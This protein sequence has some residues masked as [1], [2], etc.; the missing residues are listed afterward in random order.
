MMLGTIAINIIIVWYEGGAGKRLDSELL[1]ADSSGTKS[2]I[3]VSF[4][5][6]VGAYFV[7]H[8]FPWLDGVITLVIA[9]FI[10]HIIVK[11]V[12]S[13]VKV[14]CDAQ[15]IDPQKIIDVV[16]SV[17][18]VR[19]CRAVRTRGRETGFYA[20]LH[21]GVEES[22][23]VAKAHDEVCHNVK[24]KLQEAFPNLR[25]ANVHIEPDKEAGR[26]RKNSVFRRSDS[27]DTR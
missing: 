9:L 5:V 15:V 19:F 27:Y 10:L 6:M 18:G 22:M 4:A 20:D 24:A 26:E 11:I 2:D 16:M 12:T 8:G 17:P 1:I 3:F 21:M 7:G 14:L 23:T 13:T 25:A